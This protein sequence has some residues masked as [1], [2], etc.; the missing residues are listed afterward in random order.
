MVSSMDFEQI[1]PRLSEGGTEALLQGLPVGLAVENEAGTVLW[2]NQGLEDL[3]GCAGESLSGQSFADWPLKGLRPGSDGTERFRV[4]GNGES[5]KLVCRSTQIKDADGQSLSLRCFSPETTA[6]L[7]F[8]S[9]AGTVSDG[10]IDADTGTL[11]RLSI[12]QAIRSEVS[13]S[14]RYLNP[15]SVI[16][17]VVQSEHHEAMRVAAR[18]LKEQTRWA[19]ILGRW[20]ERE[21][22]LI[23]PETDGDSVTGLIAKINKGIEALASTGNGD[24]PT[25]ELRFGIASWQRGDDANLLM[26]RA[27]SVLSTD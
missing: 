24:T 10:G 22:L 13:R 3:L 12:S 27:R 15:F 5:H 8:N 6:K 18:I 14:R 20:N 19:D 9:A 7:S 26:E 25:M 2:V 4:V 21:F 11:N 17:M 23:L 1:F 16:L